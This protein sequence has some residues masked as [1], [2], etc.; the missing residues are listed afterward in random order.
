MIESLEQHD[1][2]LENPKCLGVAM[3]QEKL[4]TILCVGTYVIGLLRR[5]WVHIYSPETYK[6]DSFYI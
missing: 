6:S 5:I 1:V 4:E 3:R 2:Y